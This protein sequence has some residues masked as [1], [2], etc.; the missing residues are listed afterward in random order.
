[1]GGCSAGVPTLGH[2]REGV[3]SVRDQVGYVH[4]IV[5]RGDPLQAAGHDPT[6]IGLKGDYPVSGGS[7]AGLQD[8][9]ARPG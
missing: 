7:D 8:S 3:A 9:L 1:M 4:V 2:H 5:R 6:G